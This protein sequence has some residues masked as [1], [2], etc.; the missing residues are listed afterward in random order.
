MMLT[1]TLTSA[2]REVL[3]ESL[4]IP[5]EYLDRIR[6]VVAD[7]SGVEF[8][9]DDLDD[10]FGYVASE[11]NHCKSRKKQKVLDLIC[12]KMQRLLEG[13]EDDGSND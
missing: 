3:S 9:S 6:L 12:Q 5:D 2:E 11:A 4:V 10:F 1:L 7:D 8:T 13:E